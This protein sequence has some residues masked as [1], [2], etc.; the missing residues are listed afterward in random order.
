MSRQ[1]SPPRARDVQGRFIS[2]GEGLDITFF[3]TAVASSAIRAVGYDLLRQRMT[4]LFVRGKIYPY[5]GVP[6]GVYKS[7]ISASSVGEYYNSYIRGV[8]NC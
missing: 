7:L 2:T 1:P 3:Q 4:I 5:C 6:Y 8:Y